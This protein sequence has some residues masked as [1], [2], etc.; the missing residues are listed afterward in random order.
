[1]T[2]DDR[3]TRSEYAT[4][5]LACTRCRER[6][7]RCGRERPEC[8]NC[9]RD[10]GATCVYQNPAKRVNHIKLLCDNFDLLQGRLGSMESNL[11][12]LAAA[13]AQGN[14]KE[15]ETSS[16]SSQQ[17]VTRE[18]NSDDELDDDG[19]QSDPDLGSDLHIFRNKIDM[20]DRYHGP[21]SL[22]VLCKRIR[23]HF[24]APAKA[25]TSGTH[26]EDLLQSLCEAAGASD[27]FSFHTDQPSVHLVP[28][29]QAAT[30]VGHF[31]QHLDIRTDIFSHSN[32]LANLECIYS[33]PPKPGD[34]AWTSCFKAIALLVLGMELSAQAKNALFGDFARSFLPSR[35]ALVNSSLLSTPRLIN[36]QTL[37]LLSIAM[38]QFDPPGWAEFLFTHACILARTMG[39]QH[40]QICPPDTSNEDTLERAKVLR[41]L[42]AQDRSLCITSGAVSWLP[43]H[44]CRIASQLK[45]AVDRQAPYADRLR[46]SVIQDKVYRMTHAAGRR[47]SG[48]SS[49]SRATMLSLEQQLSDY[50]RVFGIFESETPF[51]PRQAMITLEFL[52]TRIM[53][54][55]LSSEPD[56]VTQIRQDARASCLLLLIAHGEQDRATIEDFYSSISREPTASPRKKSISTIE[57]GTVPFGSIFDSF[58]VPAFFILL[59]DLVCNTKEEET[60]QHKADLDLLRKVSACYS[61]R[62]GRMQSNNYHRKVS[63]VFEQLLNLMELLKKARHQATDA[64]LPMVPIAEMI[65]QHLTSHLSPFQPDMMDFSHVHAGTTQGQMP[66]LPQ[67]HHPA[68]LFPGIAGL[69]CLR[70]F[71]QPHHSVRRT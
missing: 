7:I 26:L 43:S 30:A 51:S 67:H 64:S 45:A 54:L 9:E 56:C 29:R 66:E 70:R 53:A 41:S 6:K 28:K 62:T 35:A 33:Q 17:V 23:T 58:S 49:K 13:T 25:T 68:H 34:D 48:R 4:P 2:A 40:I 12:R 39:L 57:T 63:W 60:T 52:A 16:A 3:Q 47:S 38:R 46:L 36:V 31:L 1:M 42:Y 69:Q 22:F 21:S 44:D 59:E 20:A 65:P 10:G 8:S 55:Q 71:C 50:A 19:S 18:S 5:D 27:P 32:L 11:A 37:I 15:N 61:L 24:A 14:E